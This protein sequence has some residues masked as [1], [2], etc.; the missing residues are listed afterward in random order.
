MIM[1]GMGLTGGLSSPIGTG[2]LPPSGV[3]PAVFLYTGGAWT[4][5]SPTDLLELSGRV[6]LVYGHGGSLG[7][8]V[9]L[10]GAPDSVSASDAGPRFDVNAT[11]KKISVDVKTAAPGGTDYLI[12]V[13]DKAMTTTYGSVTLS[14]GA[15]SV[16]S[17]ALAAVIPAN[18]S[19]LVVAT[20][21]V[22]GGSVNTIAVTVEV[23]K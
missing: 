14:G 17:G 16:S 22:G 15:G 11:L 7:P 19:I 3:D 1:S 6:A 12:S 4:I 20:R 23:E 13:M 8:G 9:V 10:K 2:D 5:V 21:T 18:T